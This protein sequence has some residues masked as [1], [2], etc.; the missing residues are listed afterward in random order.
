MLHSR[1]RAATHTNPAYTLDPSPTT[2]PRLPIFHNLTPWL[3][4]ECPG[5]RHDSH[6][7]CGLVSSSDPRDTECTPAPIT[8]A[9]DAQY[10]TASH[11]ASQHCCGLFRNWDPT[12][13]IAPCIFT[14]LEPRRIPTAQVPAHK[15]PMLP[16][17]QRHPRAGLGIKRTAEP[18]HFL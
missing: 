8:G 5:L 17:P 16:P 7:C 14:L 13:A 3:S 2:A 9:I 6:G 18:K 1:N 12:T 15:T 10:T 11:T 4:A